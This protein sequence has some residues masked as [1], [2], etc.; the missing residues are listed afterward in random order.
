MGGNVLSASTAAEILFGVFF[1]LLVLRVPVAVSL[2][3]ACLPILLI[4]PRLS[5]M[6]LAQETFNAYNSFIL[7]AVPFFLLTANLMNIGGITDRLMNFSRALV[8]HFPG[9][10]AQINVVLSIFFAGI[11]GSS[12]ADAA[13]Q[14]KIFIEAQRKEGYDDSFSVAITAVSAVLAV[15]IP[16]SILMIVWGGVLTVSIGALFLAGI[17]PGLLIGL[18]Q[19]GTVHAYAKARGYPTYPRATLGV[20]GRTFLVS[21]PALTTPM[22]IIGGKIFGWF[23]ATESACIAVL[24]AG[25]LSLVVYREMTWRGL[26]DAL[27]ETGRLAGVALFCVGTASAFGWLLAFYQIPEALLAGVSAWGMGP[28]ATGFF[29]AGVFLVVG[30]FLD[31]IPAIIIVGAILQ[32]LA[33]GVGMDPVHFAMIGI[34]S[35]AF[36]LVTP[37]YGLC[38]MIACS[39]AGMRIADALKDTCIMLL[40][41]LA[42][43]A[44]IIVFPQ[45]V[46][47]LPNLI[48]PE[49]LR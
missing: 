46:L 39:V 40:P 4:E 20:I 2:G 29:I 34:V 43:L 30:C 5:P 24:Y 23:T 1:L 42:V 37:P 13:S 17:V 49:F 45:V 27:G 12:T 21:I 15:I 16:P 44:A 8:G 19:M 26:V 14:S 9:G 32:P 47:F 38:L 48:S 35:L 41:M 7:L 3:L 6:M 33:Q 31:A 28:I 25:F 10:L 18:V 11:S 22:I 36:G